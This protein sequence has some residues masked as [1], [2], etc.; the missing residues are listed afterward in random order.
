[1]NSPIVGA[2][3]L[4]DHHM[5]VVDEHGRPV[6][7]G[8]QVTVDVWTLSIILA[9]LVILSLGYLQ[10]IGWKNAHPTPIS[11]NIE[12]APVRPV[13]TIENNMP[14]PKVVVKIIQAPAPPTIVTPNTQD[15]V[16]PD[17]RQ[18]KVTVIPHSLTEPMAQNDPHVVIP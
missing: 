7:R 16:Q 15:E 9:A 12:P 10:F 18:P 14:K 2:G 11:V 6:V 13:W 17:I 1:M 4:A 8:I 3:N 5:L